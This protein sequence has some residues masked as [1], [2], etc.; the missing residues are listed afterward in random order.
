MKKP[1]IVFIAAGANSRFFPLNTRTHK[2]NLSLLGE[3]ILKRAIKNVIEHG[4][5]DI[6]LVV[7]KKDA[8]GETLSK[9]LDLESL[10]ATITVV[11]QPVAKGQGDAILTASQYLSGDF[12]V[13]SP[14]YLDAGKIADQ[15]YQTKQATKADCVLT[16]LKTDTPSLFGI[17]KLDGERVLE[18][19]EKPAPGTEPSNMRVNSIY[20]FDQ[21]FLEFLKMTEE[22]EYSLEAAYSN[23]AQ[24]AHITF[25]LQPH[26]VITLKY[27]WHLF[28]FQSLLFEKMESYLDDTAIV[29][30]TAIIDETHGPVHIA[31]HA[32]I[33][34]FAVII[35]PAY[36]GEHAF[37]GQYCLIRS[38][39]LEKNVIIGAY[40]EIVRSI[41]FEKV[42][43]HQSYLAD[44]ILGADTSVG[45]GLITANKR[46]DG[47]S[48]QTMIKGKIIETNRKKMGVITGVATKIGIRV[49][50]MPG[51]LI[52]QRNTILPSRT[53]SKNIDHQANN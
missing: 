17:A 32:K 9:L 2:G 53:V 12:I 25:F 3:P 18:V 35:G 16:G 6:V 38:S 46:L 26:E 45:A 22:S 44:S 23:Y 27:A 52:G 20:L 8:E 36:I 43:I 48:V 1:T 11:T 40:T 5:T 13:T 24:K 30:P 41:V 37:V 7:S 28:D 19:V 29:A 15:L 4:F 21:G 10:S 47:E 14:Y 39:T 42:T 51:V 33:D 49:N 31:A 50:T 34:N